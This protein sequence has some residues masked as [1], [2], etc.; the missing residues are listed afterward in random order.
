MEKEFMAFN[1]CVKWMGS[2]EGLNYK[3]AIQVLL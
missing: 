1:K 2:L 3:G